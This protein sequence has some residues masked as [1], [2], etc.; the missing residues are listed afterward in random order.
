MMR[1]T[2]LFG[3]CATAVVLIFL[4][5]TACSDNAGISSLPVSTMACGS[6]APGFSLEAYADPAHQQEQCQFKLGTSAA[7]YVQVQNV[8][9]SGAYVMFVQSTGPH[10]YC[11]YT[12]PTGRR[13]LPTH[14]LGSG[15]NK[16]LCDTSTRNVSGVN[17]PGGNVAFSWV[18]DS[19]LGAGSYTIGIYDQ[20]AN[21]GVGAVLASTQV[22]LTH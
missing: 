5:L 6:G 13:A 14:G 11:V 10:P 1:S 21:G 22:D 15:S 16:N 2:A 19:T 7:A 17:A 3:S 18:F 12:S 4:G 20:D 9:T 8:A